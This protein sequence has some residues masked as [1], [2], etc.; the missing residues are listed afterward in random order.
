MCCCWPAV[1]DVARRTT[2]ERRR[3]WDRQQQVQAAGSLD[4][5]LSLGDRLQEFN[6]TLSFFRTQISFGFSYLGSFQKLKG[7]VRK[8]RL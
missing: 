1:V 8:L 2:R 7:I 4:R 3:G 6:F 5:A